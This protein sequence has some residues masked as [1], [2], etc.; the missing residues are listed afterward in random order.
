MEAGVVEEGGAGF[1]GGLGRGWNKWQLFF[2]EVPEEI[3]KEILRDEAEIL[4]R[5]LEVIEKRLKEIETKE[6]SKEV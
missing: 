5:R 4:K 3:Q 1:F 6:T 2:K